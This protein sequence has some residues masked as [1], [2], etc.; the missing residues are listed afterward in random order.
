MISIYKKNN[1][2]ILLSVFRYAPESFNNGLFSHA[3]DVW[4]FGVTLWEMFSLGESPY[5]DIRGI[6]AIEIIEKGER[7]P[8]PHLCPDDIYDIMQGCWSYKPKNRPTFRFLRDYFSRDPDYQNIIEL[9]Q[10]EHIS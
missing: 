4:S 6:D 9:I 1:S 8:Q 10:T 7:L 3:S 2:L 5:G